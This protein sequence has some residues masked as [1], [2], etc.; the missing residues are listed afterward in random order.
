VSIYRL[1][2]GEALRFPDLGQMLYD[3]GK[4][5]YLDWLNSYLEAEVRA[6][7]LVVPDIPAAS[8]AFLA[9]IAGEVFWPELMVPGCG[10]TDKQVAVIVDEAVAMMLARYGKR[11]A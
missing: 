10:G 7:A 5:P 1:I 3:K 2:I 4:G 6:G 9:M 8:R 11:P